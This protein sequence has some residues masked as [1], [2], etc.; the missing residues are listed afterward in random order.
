MH[1][2]RGANDDVSL[3]LPDSDIVSLILLSYAQC[4]E[5][6][7]FDLFFCVP[8]MQGYIG[9]ASTDTYGIAPR[10]QANA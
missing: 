8:V 3:R 1:C 9:H 5:M 6:L 4:E 2:R 7:K 10:R